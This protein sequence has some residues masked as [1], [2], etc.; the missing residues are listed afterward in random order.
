MKMH[1]NQ[2]EGLGDTVA[3]LTS[4]LKIDKLVKEITGG[5]GI[6]D[7]GCER[8]KEKL[9]ELFP[10]KKDEDKKED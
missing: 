10:Y 7:C 3:Y 1:K 5:L 2:D 4:L 8:R 6:E 9:N